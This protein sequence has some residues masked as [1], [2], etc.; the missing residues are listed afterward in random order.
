LNYTAVCARARVFRIE[1]EGLNQPVSPVLTAEKIVRAA[2]VQI[3]VGATAYGAAAE[4]AADGL[5]VSI[6]HCKFSFFLSWFVGS[7]ASGVA[8]LDLLSLATFS[9]PL[10]SDWRI[11]YRVSGHSH[12]AM[13]RGLPP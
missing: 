8:L 4:E 5:P 12:R 11:G 10:A 13:P 1:V 2:N 6:G 9:S 7:Q 3:S